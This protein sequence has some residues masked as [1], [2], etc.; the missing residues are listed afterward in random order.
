MPING[1]WYFLPGTLGI[2]LPIRSLIQEKNSNIYTKMPPI[3]HLFEQNFHS[4]CTGFEISLSPCSQIVSFLSTSTLKMRERY[5]LFIKPTCWFEFKQAGF[6][7]Q[8]WMVINDKL[9]NKA[10][11]LV[12]N[13]FSVWHLNN[14]SNEPKFEQTLRK[15]KS[16]YIGHK[17][18]NGTEPCKKS[19]WSPTPS[20][21]FNCTLSILV[22]YDKVFQS[23]L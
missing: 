22:S 3:F 4:I 1:N 15:S 12:I 6:G 13:S 7:A 21:I 19:G 16:R 20:Q 17:C 11:I 10:P 8:S 18:T 23:D 2:H 14:W 5:E 9:F